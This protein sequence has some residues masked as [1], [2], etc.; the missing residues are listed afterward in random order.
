MSNQILH[1]SLLR[2]PILCILRA[3]GFQATRPSVLDTIV[4]L[5]ARY[6]AVLAQNIHNHAILNHND[7]D[8][9]VTDVRMALQYA[10][11][12]KPQLSEMEEKVT[13]MEDMRGIEAFL[14]WM[15]GP[16][17]RE[18]KRIAGMVRTEG[19]LANVSEPEGK[20]DFLTGNSSTFLLVFS[21]RL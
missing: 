16:E 9:T 6:F 11:A 3:A 10:G 17:H 13:G 15:A 5:A 14:G 21:A 12:L 20:E 1:T 7:L 19:G 2:P 8:I 18:I 4:D